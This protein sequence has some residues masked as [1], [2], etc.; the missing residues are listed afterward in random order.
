MTVDTA[1]R[2]TDLEP[3]RT[4]L[5]GVLTLAAISL[6]GAVI[7]VAGDLSPSLLDA[8]G[9]DGHLSIPLP[10]IAVQ[11]AL[12]V[13]AG[14]RRRRVALAGSGLLA[15]ALFVSVISGFFDGGYSDDRLTAPERVCQVTLVAGLTAVAVV[16]AVRFW[17]VLRG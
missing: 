15:A 11:V 8:M 5:Y 3:S 1:S 17:R 10:M 13:A 12:A 16:A 14:S 9:P 7:S 6:V 2:R 4:V